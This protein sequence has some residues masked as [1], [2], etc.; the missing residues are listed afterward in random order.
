MSEV[1][2]KFGALKNF[3]TELDATRTRY[4]VARTFNGATKVVYACFDL[5]TGK[6]ITLPCTRIDPDCDIWQ[7]QKVDGHVLASG[8]VLDAVHAFCVDVAHTHKLVPCTYMNRGLE[9]ALEQKGEGVRASAKLFV[10]TDTVYQKLKPGFFGKPLT[11]SHDADG[12]NIVSVAEEGDTPPFVWLC[13]V[14]DEGLVHLLAISGAPGILTGIRNIGNPADLLA[15]N[16]DLETVNSVTAVN[17]S[18][19]HM[20]PKNILF[21]K[22]HTDDR[23]TPLGFAVVAGSGSD[24][25]PLD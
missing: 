2:A 20:E 19:E 14:P 22:F 7:V 15:S 5:E 10:L 12:K 25:K 17:F 24:F 18:P 13:K 21:L 3:T 16:P 6:V 1:D 9:E 23:V 11:W 4:L 8:H